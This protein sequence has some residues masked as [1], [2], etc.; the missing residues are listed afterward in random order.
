MPNTTTEPND[1]SSNNHGFFSFSHRINVAFLIGGSGGT[2][3]IQDHTAFPY[4]TA[5]VG[6]VE[7]I[8][9]A[10]NHVT[11]LRLGA[12]RRDTTHI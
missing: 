7:K 2:S 4:P 5:S 11:L 10:R 12:S 6:F 8:T 1:D 3:L 9:P